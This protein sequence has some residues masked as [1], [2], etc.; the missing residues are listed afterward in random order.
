VTTLVHDYT[1]RGSCVD[2]FSCRDPELLLSGPAGTGKSRACLEKLHLMALINPGMRGL[3][4]RKT[5]VSLASSGLVTWRRDVIP[6]SQA[7]GLV[8]FYGGSAVEAAQYRYRNGSTVVVGGLD[9]ASKIMSTEYDLIYVQEATE[10]TAEDWEALTTRLRNGKVSFQQLLADCNPDA[11]TH[12]LHQRALSG[13]T[14]MLEARHTDNPR[15]YAED[16]TV[17][18][19]G[20]DYMAKL[21]A[22]TGVRRLRLRQGLWSTAEGVIFEEWDPTI[23]VVDRFEIPDEWD[24]IISVDFG[25]TNP[26]VVQ[27]WAV[28]ADGRMFCYR[29][30][31]RTKTLVADMAAE[32][33]GLMANEPR[34][35]MV[36]TDH[37][38]EG[39]AQ[40]RKILGIGTTAA[41]K[42]VTE[43]LQA[44]AERLRVAGDGRPRLFF[45]R[46]ALVAPDGDLVE[47]SMPTCTIEEIPAYV[48]DTS[49]RVGVK[50]SPVKAD[51]H[52]CDAMRYA[53]MAL[54]KKKPHS[55]RWM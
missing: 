54:D 33:A 1:P 12:W 19:Y 28:D 30:L 42:Q 5:Q 9:K 35:K 47:A 23:H 48:W 25:F 39:R 20:A 6:E 27:W 16:G 17:T 36:V 52:G 21:D 38:A 26:M 44:V 2:L 40:L 50:E 22:L 8:E 29:E 10:L 37:D 43:G 32:V 51:D 41:R 45:F 18:P 14:T 46:D 11:A 49:G 31:Y 7:A 13:R 15:L 4:V 55:V 24:R 34:P 3:M 53:V